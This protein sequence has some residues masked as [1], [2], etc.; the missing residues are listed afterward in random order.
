MCW[1][2]TVKC[3]DPASCEAGHQLTIRAGEDCAEYVGVWL[4]EIVKRANDWTDDD[5][6]D[7]ELAVD[8]LRIYVCSKDRLEAE[9][10][11]RETFVYCKECHWRRLSVEQQ[12]GVKASNEFRSEMESLEREFGGGKIAVN[13]SDF[14]AALVQA[15]GDDVY[16]SPAVF[17]ADVQNERKARLRKLGLLKQERFRQDYRPPKPISSPPRPDSQRTF[18]RTRERTHKIRDPERDGSISHAR[19]HGRNGK[20]NPEHHG[21]RSEGERRTQNSEHGSHRSELRPREGDRDSFSP[22]RP[23]GNPVK[24]VIEPLFDIR[25]ARSTFGKPREAHRQ[26]GRG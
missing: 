2:G 22:R 10:A 9:K 7:P 5:L 1:Y 23:R 25:L 8:D 20:A 13:F 17:I 14:M 21:H 11:G 15:V 12:E 4:C 3:K 26:T 6:S 18:G 16:S 19:P 24:E